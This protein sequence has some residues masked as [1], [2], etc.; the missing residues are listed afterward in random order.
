MSAKTHGHGQ[1]AAHPHGHH[2]AHDHHGGAAHGSRRE[3]W[4][5]FILSV[6]LTAPAFGLVMTGVIADPRVTAGIVMALAM[7]QIVVHMIYFLH[8]NTKSENG[9]TMLAL[10]FTAIIVLIAFAAIEED[11]LALFAGMALGLLAL[12]G[13]G[14]VAW[15]MLQAEGWAL[16]L[17]HRLGLAG[18]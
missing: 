17:L 18:G 13:G 3:Y 15:Q 2:D 8:M 11:G 14:L 16:A 5:G 6:L 12:V 9:W 1:E 4:I 10:I 7:V